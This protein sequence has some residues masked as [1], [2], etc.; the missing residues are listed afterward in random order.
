VRSG[1]SDSVGASSLPCFAQRVQ[2]MGI[3]ILV[4]RSSGR[5]TNG[6][7]MRGEVVGR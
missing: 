4:D 5:Q 6:E 2:G 7:E 1:S 3:S